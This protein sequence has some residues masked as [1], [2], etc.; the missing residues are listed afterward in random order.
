MDQ[1]VNLMS[2]AEA[3]QLLK[4]HQISPT[5]QRVVVAQALFIREQH[6]SAEQVLDLVQLHGYRVSK[7]TIYNTLGLFVAKGMVKERLV[8]P[9]KVYYD[10]NVKEHHHLYNEDTGVLT[11]MADDC[12]G[13][14]NLPA[15]PE[16]T[17]LHDVEIVVRIRNS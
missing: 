10:T 17:R 6:L 7:A 11:D 12:F 4:K 1:C 13:N 14:I 3:V 8:D 15:L 2:V 9:S 16:G 5:Q